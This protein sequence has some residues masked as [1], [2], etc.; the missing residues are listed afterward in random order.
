MNTVS[1][2]VGRYVFGGLEEDDIWRMELSMLSV[3]R[4]RRCC[5]YGTVLDLMRFDRVGGGK[6]W[7]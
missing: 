1:E 7:L 4:M 3:G 5:R 2:I 6:M